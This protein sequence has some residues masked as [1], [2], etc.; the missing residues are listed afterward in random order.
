MFCPECGKEI[1]DEAKK[2]SEY[3][4]S[5]TAIVKPKTYNRILVAKPFI[6]PF[7]SDFFIHQISGKILFRFYV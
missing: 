5:A 7:G 6:T 2:K 4:Y 1:S 3:C